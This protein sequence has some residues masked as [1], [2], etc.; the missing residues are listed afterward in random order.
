VKKELKKVGKELNELHD[1]KKKF[2]MFGAQSTI[3][4]RAL[5]EFKDPEKK[6]KNYNH[7]LF[8]GW[9]PFL[10]FMRTWSFIDFGLFLRSLSIFVPQNYN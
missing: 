6:F 7:N 4:D 1:N 8:E 3:F 2:V 9:Q 5:P 10:K